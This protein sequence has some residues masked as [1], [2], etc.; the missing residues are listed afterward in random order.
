MFKIKI[1][2]LI[3]NDYAVMMGL[4][5]RI[6][7]GSIILA[8]FIAIPKLLSFFG[9]SHPVVDFLVMPVIAL[10]LFVL[11]FSIYAGPMVL[12]PARFIIIMPCILIFSLVLVFAFFI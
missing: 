9:I 10:F 11:I 2:E 8:C 6:V 1:R 5:L 3:N 7:I 4:P 12:N